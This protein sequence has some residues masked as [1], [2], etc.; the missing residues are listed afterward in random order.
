MSLGEPEGPLSVK[1]G[2]GGKVGR[3]ADRFEDLAMAG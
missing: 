2:E 1:A 3:Q